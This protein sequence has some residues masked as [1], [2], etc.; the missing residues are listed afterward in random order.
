MCS[1][2]FNSFFECYDAYVQGRAETDPGETWYRGELGFFDFYII[3]LA[4]KLKDCGVFGVNSD[5]Y[6]NY[7]LTNRREWASRGLEVVEEYKE[8]IKKRDLKAKQ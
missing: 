7:A 1:F 8:A 3:P 5:E 4:R 2:R 6:L